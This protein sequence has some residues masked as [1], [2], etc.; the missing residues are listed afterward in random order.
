M[1]TAIDNCEEVRINLI[2]VHDVIAIIKEA[3]KIET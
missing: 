3:S 2:V 1:Q